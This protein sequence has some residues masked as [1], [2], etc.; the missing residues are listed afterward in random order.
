M[1]IGKTSMVILVMTTTFNNKRSTL[2]AKL[3][4]LQPTT[5]ANHLVVHRA[6]LEADRPTQREGM[7]A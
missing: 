5:P 6:N 1:R 7:L 3:R 2:D 4:W